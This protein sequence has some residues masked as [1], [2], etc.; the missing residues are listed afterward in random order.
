MDIV[1]G[2]WALCGKAL[3]G[4]DQWADAV[5]GALAEV[6]RVLRPDG[7]IILIESLGTGQE[8]PSPPNRRFAEYFH[9]L[10]ADG[11]Q[12]T[13]IRTDYRFE[14]LEEKEQLLTFFFDKEMLDAGVKV[15]TDSLVY[16]ECTGIW[17]KRIR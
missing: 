11:F 2:G 12:R 8:Q 17:W 3:R 15:Q 9:L 5:R 4:G 13:S 10:E 1:L 7:T 6:R 14:S 16:P